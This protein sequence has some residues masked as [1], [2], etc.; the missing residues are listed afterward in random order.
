MSKKKHL[1]I[2][3]GP[4]A[5]SAVDTMRRLGN[6]E[7]ITMVSREESLPYS[8]AALPYVLGG[9]TTEGDLFPRKD[10]YFSKRRVAFV[11]GREAVQIIPDRKQVVYRNGTTEQYDKLLIACGAEPVAQPIKGSAAG[12][13]PAFHTYAD[14][15]RLKD[16]IRGGCDVTVLGAGMV[17]VELAVA[18]IETGC[19]VRIIG[20]G[21]P[22]RAYFDEEAGG[23]IQDILVD[24]GVKIL[25]GKSIS[26]VS[27][28]GGCLTIACT[29]GEA[30]ET[31]VVVSCLGVR[32]NLRLVQGAG[33]A[34]NQGILVD[35]R[36]RTSLEGVY[37][38]GDIAEGSSFVDGLSGVCAILPEAIAQGRVAGANM[39]GRETDYEGWIA[40]N[41]LKLFGYSAFS[42]GV[43]M[44][45]HGD[46]KVIENKD[47]NR[48]YF[49]RLVVRDGK[50]IGAMFVNVDV[51]PG[52]F[53]YLIRKRV[54]VGAYEQALLDQPADVSRWLMMK[55]ERGE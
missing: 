50:M 49:E 5:L 55:A 17:A 9:R 51:D 18:L 1:I 12:E 19:S 34:V 44:P 22:L 11:T 47:R 2:G 53:S 10:D 45:G 39:A 32:P 6:D 52:V 33:I 3:C 25:T 26:Q 16:A 8:P 28:S 30:F 21:R 14:Y 24:R 36:M 37:A 35:T 20:R 27:K 31:G 40:M 38:A 7:D 43:T 15:R 13:L 54:N 4:A 23:H 46:V 41:L 42:V 48:R 29:D